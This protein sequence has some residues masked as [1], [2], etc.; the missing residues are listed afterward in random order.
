MTANKFVPQIVGIALVRNEDIFIERSIRNVVDFCDRLI[1]ADHFSTDGTFAILERLAGEFPGKIELVRIAQVRESHFLISG[2]ANSATWVFA[3]D[4]DEIYDPAGLARLREKLRAGQYSD[5]WMIFGNVLNCVRW[6]GSRATGY[7]SPPSRS[8]TKLF[9]FS[10]IESWDGA[11]SHVCHNGSIVFKP[12]RGSAMR[13]NLHEQFAWEESDFRCL[14]TCFLRRSSLDPLGAE[15]RPNV[16]ESR[17]R[18]PILFLRRLIYRWLGK[19]LPSPW[20]HEKYRRGALTALEV[21][22]F[23]HESETVL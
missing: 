19:T 20:K 13:L 12:G 3:V 8:M 23:V 5:W 14:H 17:R 18:G 2:L 15:S 21:D 1:V 7:L 10:L 6:E 22:A 4:G 16:S 11:V 9:N